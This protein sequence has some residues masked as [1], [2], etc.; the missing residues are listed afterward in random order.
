MK[1]DFDT[2]IDRRNTHS[3]KWDLPRVLYNDDDILPMWVADMD[4]NTA[5]CVIEAVKHRAELGVFGYMHRSDAF[6][7]AVVDWL[8]RRHG[9]QVKPDLKADE[10]VRLLIQ[11]AYITSDGYKIINSIAFVNAVENK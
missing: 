9:W 8:K 7:D 2:V 11:T 1:F 3:I 6:A 4:F 5:P 10:I